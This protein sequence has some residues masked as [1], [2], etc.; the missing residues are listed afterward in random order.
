MDWDTEVDIDSRTEFLEWAQQ[1]DLLHVLRFPR[2]IFGEERSINSLSFHIFVDASKYATALFIRVESD[3]EIEVHLLEAK[4]RVAPKEK[5]TIPRLELLTAT[6]G[7]RMMHSF[8]KATN[9]QNVKRYFWSDSTTVLT[10]IRQTKQWAVFVWNRVQEIRNITDVNSW[11]YVP[12]NLNPADLPSRGCDPKKFL[13]SRWWQ[14]PEWLKLP[15]EKWPAEEERIDEDTVNKELCKTSNRFKKKTHYQITERETIMF[16][17][18]EDHE[19]EI[20]WYLRKF[21]NYSKILRM[22]AWIL[23][24][25][26]SCRKNYMCQT[27]LCAKEIAAAEL[28]LCKIAQQESSLRIGDPR[29]RGLNTFEENGIIRTKTLIVNR[30]DTFGFRC[31]IILDPTHLLTKKIIYHT[32]LEFKHAGINIIMNQLRE[33]FWILRCRHTVRSVIHKCTIC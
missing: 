20:P 9:Y 10:W 3:T 23:R 15:P 13:E 32:H 12:G 17:F 24:F 7:A 29:L 14:G 8:D 6:I 25:V 18:E 22:I 31:P 1:L 27:E 5:K 19:K 11:R 26:N 2:W 4:S 28:L 21:S 30:E 33:K 16:N